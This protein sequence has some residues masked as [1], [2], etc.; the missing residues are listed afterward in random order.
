MAIVRLSNVRPKISNVRPEISN[1]RPE[2]SN[3]RPEISNVR[4]TVAQAIHLNGPA[5]WS[6]LGTV[7]SSCFSSHFAVEISLS[8]SMPVS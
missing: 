5:R 7:C 4:L 8:R 3:V 6:A 2:I 1:V